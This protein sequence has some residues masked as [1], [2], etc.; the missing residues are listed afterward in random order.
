ME[1]VQ[2]KISSLEGD[3]M[4][5][6]Q[7]TL[8]MVLTV[9]DKENR[10]WGGKAL[11]ESIQRTV[12]GA[13]EIYVIL[14]ERLGQE[15]DDVKV[16]VMLAVLAEI[17]KI[18][19]ERKGFC[20]AVSRDIP[21][22]L[23]R[24]FTQKNAFLPPKLMDMTSQDDSDNEDDD[25]AEQN[26]PTNMDLTETL[27][28][29][30]PDL[31]EILKILK[32]N[33][34]SSDVTS[35][36][37]GVLSAWVQSRGVS[38]PENVP[39]LPSEPLDTLLKSLGGG[40]YHHTLL[41]PDR[42]KH[43]EGI[44]G[45]EAACDDHGFTYSPV[46]LAVVV[47]RMKTPVAMEPQYVF[48]RSV[49]H[50]TALLGSTSI[51]TVREGLQAVR[52]VADAVAAYSISYQDSQ[53]RDLEKGKEIVAAE[54]FETLF[55]LAQSLAHVMTQCPVPWVRSEADETLQSVIKPLREF[56]RLKMYTSFVHV[57]PY[58]SV[59]GVTLMRLKNEIDKEYQALLE[60]KEE[61]R[62]LLLKS[63]AFLQ[64]SVCTFLIDTIARL[65][66]SLHLH[67][68][69]VAS[70]LSLLLFVTLRESRHSLLSLTSDTLAPLRTALTKLSEALE[71]LPPS[72]SVQASLL[73]G[74]SIER[75]SEVLEGFGV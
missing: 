35:Y 64:K 49:K 48:E 38:S 73:L 37:L 43:C 22:C 24:V 46:G 16:G 74:F 11:K 72:S 71:S 42:K 56:S 2:N 30:Y 58:P 67:V 15:A 45:A 6:F 21:E 18:L 61:V 23:E 40:A 27:D 33:G 26:D 41:Y 13:R 54:G 8:E 19:G 12:S 28:L 63:S 50:H 4:D 60:A 75:L 32:Q 68:E 62:P 1:E 5:I 52:E 3:P 25:D 44:F 7:E 14:Q 47:A 17:M 31:L 57:C 36:S 20:K 65:T 66:P 59:V 53:E 10:E 29:V 9:L 69:P 70:A 34:T 39:A 51:H 55:E